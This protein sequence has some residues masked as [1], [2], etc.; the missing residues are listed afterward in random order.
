MTDVSVQGKGVGGA[1]ISEMSQCSVQTPSWENM[2]I[3]ILLSL[4]ELE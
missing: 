1:I 2:H 3:L 4:S